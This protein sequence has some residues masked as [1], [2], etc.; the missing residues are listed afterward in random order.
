MQVVS[1]TMQVI[2]EVRKLIRQIPKSSAPAPADVDDDDDNEYEGAAATAGHGVT[3]KQGTPARTDAAPRHKVQQRAA[4]SQP[5]K[6]KRMSS[7]STG[8]A[9]KQQLTD[10]TGGV[11]RTRSAVGRGNAAGQD[12]SQQQVSACVRGTTLVGT[13]MRIVMS[14]HCASQ[15]TLTNKMK[16]TT[17]SLAQQTS[18]YYITGTVLHEAACFACDVQTTVYMPAS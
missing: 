17:L 1:F 6:K 15:L 13:R 11:R 18:L 7:P 10:D 12:Q 9:T 16:L 8:D 5:A 14:W 3:S 4:D 2:T